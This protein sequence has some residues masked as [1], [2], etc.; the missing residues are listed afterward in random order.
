MRA[1]ESITVV[2]TAVIHMVHLA[3]KLLLIN[4]LP[5]ANELRTTST[6]GFLKG[7]LAADV[8]LILVG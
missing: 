8:L 2:L 5:T 1:L 4:R 6:C 3:L 7:L